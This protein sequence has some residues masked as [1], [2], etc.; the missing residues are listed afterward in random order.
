MRIISEGKLPEEEV[1]KT[2]CGRCGTRYEFARK[3]ASFVSGGQ[4][5]S[6]SLVTTCPLTGC[7]KNNYTALPDANSQWNR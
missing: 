2:T 4:R 1:F 7:G 6:D 3:E 5:E